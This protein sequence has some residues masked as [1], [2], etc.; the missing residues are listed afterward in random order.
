MPL[1][2]CRMLR[3]AYR[4]STLADL[5]RPWAR[6]SA[7]VSSA[8]PAS[9][10]PPCRN[11][12]ILPTLPQRQPLTR[13]RHAADLMPLLSPLRNLVYPRSAR[14]RVFRG[15]ACRKHWGSPHRQIP[16]TAR[17][18]RTGAIGYGRRPRRRE[19]AVILDGKLELLI[20]LHTT[21]VRPLPRWNASEV[22]AELRQTRGRT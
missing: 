1:A 22:Y 17:A 15:R 4:V 2:T 19:D 8:S 18:V 7:S 20:P 10:N 13:S 11:D 5:C 9:V 3:L 21:N 12:A 14:R 6:I 16:A